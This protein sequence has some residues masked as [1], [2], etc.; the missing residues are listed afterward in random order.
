MLSEGPLGTV[1]RVLGDVRLDENRAWPLAILLCFV[2]FLLLASLLSRASKGLSLRDISGYRAIHQLVDGAAESLIPFHFS[3]GT[4]ILGGRQTADSLAGLLAMSS[5]AA[6]ASGARAEMRVTTPDPIVEAIGHGM[7]RPAEGLPRRAS[8]IEKERVQFLAPEPVAYAAGVMGALGRQRLSGSVM[9]GAF[10]DEYLLMAQ[11]AV[12]HQLPQVVG[13]T[14][15]ETLP[16]VVATTTTP[17]LGE[18][19]FAS[20]AYL[21][22]RPIYRASLLAQDWLRNLVLAVVV[23]LALLRSLGQI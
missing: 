8:A 1:L 9:V 14:A 4:G 18:E 3:P 23:G 17:L 13:A 12:S 16:F 19:V 22:E 2:A 11:A 20:G 15:P 6:R 21:T 7:M 5:V 10:G